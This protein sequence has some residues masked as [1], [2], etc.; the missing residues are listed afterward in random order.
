MGWLGVVLVVAACSAPDPAASVERP[1]AR[2]EVVAPA[3]IPSEALEEQPIQRGDL[4]LFDVGYALRELVVRMHDE[5]ARAERLR[6]EMLIRAFQWL[7]EDQGTAAEQPW[8]A[9]CRDVAAVAWALVD[10]THS[11]RRLTPAQ[12]AELLEVEAASSG[13]L[14]F[15]PTP[16]DVD[17]SAPRSDARPTG[18]YAAGGEF[19]WMASLFKASVYLRHYLS[20][21]PDA[22]RERWCAVMSRMMRKFERAAA[23]EPS[24]R[25][26]FGTAFVAPGVP[27]PVVCDDIVWL[28]TQPPTAAAHERLG[29][30]FASR[31]QRVP[32][33]VAD[34][35]LRACNELR[36]AR[37]D[38]AIFGAMAEAQWRA[39]WTDAATF[40]YAGLREIDALVQ[41]AGIRDEAGGGPRVVIE[42]LPAVWAA[43]RALERRES[44]LLVARYGSSASQPSWVDDVLEAL[45]LQE[46]G[47]DLP[48]ELEAG[49][50]ELLLFRFATP[51]RLLG[52]PA[53]IEGVSGAVRRAVPQLVRVPIRWRGETKMALALRLYVEHEVAPGEWQGPP[54]GVALQTDGA[55]AATTR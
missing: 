5:W 23:I 27:E 12:A 51:D 4:V 38:H 21:W 32:D 43:L 11:R 1:S 17:W 28:V 45:A 40:A 10:P 15:L 3:P 18:A 9:A 22:D 7:A 31:A 29:A 48:R 2:V 54:W 36:A 34:D 44:E 37:A 41:S 49:L 16:S 6:A 52:T 20:A 47:V 25:L 55:R 35:L 53:A 30:L 24:W 19:V 42:P 50:L 13:T 26:L 33:T 14:R 46:R 8:S 39:K